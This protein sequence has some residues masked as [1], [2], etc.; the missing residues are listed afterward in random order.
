MKKIKA[1][2][3]AFRFRTLP[4]AFSCIFMGAFLAASNGFFNWPILIWSLVTTLFLQVLSNLANDYGDATSGVDGEH[5]T[6]PKRTVSAGLISQSAMKKALIVFSL[7]S[8]CSGLWLI[9]LS[10]GDR[11]T[12][13]IVFLVLGLGA[14]VAAIK[15]TVGKRPYGYAGFGDL[16]VLIFFGLVGVGGSYYLYAHTL[17]LLILLPA[18]SCGLLAVGV[19]NVNNIRDIESDKLAGKHSIPVRI[20]R[21]NAIVY[22]WILLTLAMV[23]SCVYVSIM[24]P[25]G[26]SFLFLLVLPMLFSNARAVKI[27]KTS[28]GLDPFLKQLAL[29]T[30]IFVILFGIGQVLFG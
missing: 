16:F 17:N 4:L 14:I 3:Q 6:G 21:D 13:I 30:L 5:R 24:N 1:W 11:W 19:L 7:L 2:I 29:T 18:L 22:H 28:E 10:F 12:E 9:F 15:Y 8:L 20:G 27:K 25:R 23:S 26:F